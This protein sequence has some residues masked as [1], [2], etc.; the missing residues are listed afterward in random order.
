MTLTEKD[1]EKNY[2]NLW[3]TKKVEEIIKRQNLGD[4]LKQDEKIWFDNKIG[5]RKAGLNFAATTKESTEWGKCAIDV[6]YFAETY[7]HIKREDGSVGN[8]KLRDY[9]KDIIDLYTKNRFSIL[10]ASRQ[11]GKCVSLSTIVT[12]RDNN[13]HRI[14]DIT[15]GELYYI[16][17]KEERTLTVI[18]KIKYGLYKLLT[19]LNDLGT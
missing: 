19:K 13:T 15:M 17:I 5:V 3:T 1:I 12:I 14:Y 8:M 11:M 6:S 4:K 7:V 16:S 10:M 18:E 9:Q 2:K